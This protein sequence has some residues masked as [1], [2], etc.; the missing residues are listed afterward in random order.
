VKEIP[1]GD[2]VNEELTGFTL[3]STSS[4]TKKES[5]IGYVLNTCHKYSPG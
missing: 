3:P 2:D 4:N 5:R 1:A